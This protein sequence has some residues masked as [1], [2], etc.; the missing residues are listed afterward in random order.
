MLFVL[1]LARAKSISPQV[2]TKNE[3]NHTTTKGQ[4]STKVVRQE[5]TMN[6][7]WEWPWKQGMARK[8]GIGE[9]SEIL[10]VF[11]TAEIDLKI[12]KT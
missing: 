3:R 5:L 8:V 12:E 2:R 1:P 10:H 9:A 4:R 11:K 7:N 6:H